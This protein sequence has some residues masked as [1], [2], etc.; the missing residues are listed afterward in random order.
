M[1]DDWQYLPKYQQI[2][3]TLRHRITEGVYQVGDKLP[4]ES[5]LIKE[6]G[7]SRPTVV[8]A[9]NDM[10]TGGELERVHGRGSFVKTVRAAEEPDRSLPGLAVLDRHDT[11]ETVKVIEVG[12][13]ATPAPIAELLGL[14]VGAPAYLRRYVGV[15]E[16]IP[17]ELVSLWIPL[18]LAKQ[19]GLDVNGPL[20]VPVRELL[21]SANDERLVRIDERLSARSATEQEASALELAAYEP[22]LAVLGV[23]RDAT[24]RGVL[25]IDLALPGTL[26]E[27]TDSFPL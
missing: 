1:S 17:S 7:A 19:M 3:R 16:Q 5:E 14:A 11:A 13:R 10:Q 24:G 21:A 15:F 20:T 18:D 6:F 22:V 26:H 25:A 2:I 8:R 12:R 4:S 27:L 23:V 9:L